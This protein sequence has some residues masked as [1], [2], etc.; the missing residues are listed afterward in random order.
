VPYLTQEQTSKRKSDHIDLAI[1][2]Q[3]KSADERFMYEPMLS[4]HPNQQSPPFQFLGKTMK[5][6]IWVSSMTGGAERAG[7]INRNLAKACGR[8]GMG[9]GLGSCRIILDDDTFLDDFKLRKYLGDDVPFF[10]NLGIA[11]LE[12]I[13]AN[14]NYDTLVQLIDRTETD[15]LIIHVNP[16]QEWLQPEGDIISISPIE[17]IKKVLDHFDKPLIVKEVGQG[18]GK[19]SLRALMKLPLA[20]I[21]FGALG[22]TNFALLELLRSSPDYRKSNEPLAS[23]GHTAEEMVEFCNALYG[24]NDQ[25]RSKEIIISGGI[26]NFLDGYYLMKKL[27]AKSIYGQASAFLIP[28]AKGED[29]LESF[30]LNQIRGLSLAEQYLKI[31]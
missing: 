15:G 22:G 20:A 13:M 8:H 29:E 26:G 18:M 10:A 12:K 3:L 14:G 28:A 30:V 21:D 7:E 27:Q 31:K 5:A 25:Y 2:S 19:E 9:M 1:K 24:E 11:Q 23:L 4:S 16:L 6:P 17:T